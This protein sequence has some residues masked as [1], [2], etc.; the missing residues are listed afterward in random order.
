S[1]ATPGSGIQGA[2]VS[3]STVT[4]ISE[5][6]AFDN[7]GWIADGGNTTTGNNVDA[8]LD[9][10]GVNGIDPT[11]RPTG[12]PFRVFSF[13]Y[14]P[15][16]LGTDPPTGVAYRNGIVT[17]LFFWSNRYHDLI[18]QYGFTEPAGNFQNN[19]FGRGG[20]GGDFVRA[21]AQDSGGTNNANFT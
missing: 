14:N 5:L 12:S 18:Y 16:P 11:G 15:P 13:F 9:I 20:L 8:G 10:D 21:E 4:L 19:N 7:L 17:D 1:N 2:G 3:R 6:P